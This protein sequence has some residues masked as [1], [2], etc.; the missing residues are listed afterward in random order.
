M[1]GELSLIEPGSAGSTESAGPHPVRIVERPG[2]DLWHRPDVE[3]GQPRANFEFEVRS[4]VANDSPRHAVLGSLHTRIV[5]DALTE[6]S[7]PAALAGHTYLLYRHHRG[8]TVRLSGWSD[9]QRE[10]LSR[11]VSTLRAPPISAPRFEA[12]REEYARRLRNLDE[13]PPYRRAM[14]EVRELLLARDGPPIRCSRR[15]TRWGRTISATSSRGSSRAGAS[16]P[17][18]TGT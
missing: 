14:S 6:F 9:K 18:P 10:V 1:P 15:S 13:R 16:S 5:E 2:F 3:F 12:E 11:I 4:P 17:S 7:Y 8:V